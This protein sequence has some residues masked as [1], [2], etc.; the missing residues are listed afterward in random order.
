MSNSSTPL[1]NDSINPSSPESDRHD[2]PRRSLVD[3]VKL[4]VQFVSFWGAIALP[5]AHLPLL[6]QGL[7]SPQATLLFLV[8]LAANVLAL[9]V[10]HGYKR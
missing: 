8:L 10:G 6:A 4:P 7:G 2:H 1:S 3:S 9:Y 5:F